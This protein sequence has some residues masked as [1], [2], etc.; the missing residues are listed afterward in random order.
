MRQRQQNVL[1]NVRCCC[2]PV[3]VLGTLCV[4]VPAEGFQH[5]YK[6]PLGVPI[7]EAVRAFSAVQDDPR[8]MNKSV[9]FAEVRAFINQHGIKEF[10]IYSD[11]RTIEFWR[12]IPGF[13]AAQ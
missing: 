9:A 1:L 7:L 3:K 11:D 12:Q 13:M 8:P 6:I 4:P 5:G 2:Q 10:A